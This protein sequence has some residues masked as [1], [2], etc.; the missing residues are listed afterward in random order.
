VK[1]MNLRH[2]IKKMRTEVRAV[3]VRLK[4]EPLNLEFRAAHD[5]KRDILAELEY[6]NGGF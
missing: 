2:E 1:K 6:E 3:A 5:A 4:K